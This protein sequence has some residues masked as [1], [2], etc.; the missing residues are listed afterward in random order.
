MSQREFISNKGFEKVP[1]SRKYAPCVEIGVSNPH[2][3]EQEGFTLLARVDF[4]A[5]VTCVPKQAINR[6]HAPPAKC[7]LICRYDGCVDRVF[8]YD[9]LITIRGYPDKDSVVSYRP[10]K[11]VLA[12]EASSGLIGMD[13]L[14][15]WHIAIDGM[16]GAFSVSL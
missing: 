4:G 14:C 16:G 1:E 7:V 13:I 11:G 3:P 9:V 12:R 6:I 10:K 2:R 15:K 8:T 5:D